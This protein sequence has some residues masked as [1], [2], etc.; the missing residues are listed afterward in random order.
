MFR[1]VIAAMVLATC[2]VAFGGCGAAP[3]N[4]ES[5]TS[6][7]SENGPLAQIGEIYRGHW[8]STKKAPM[9]PKDIAS[10]ADG[11]PDG[12]N[13]V[14]TAAI[15]VIWGVKLDD[16]SIEGNGDSADEVLAYEKATPEAGG[17]Y[18]MKNR[19]IRKMTAAEF[20]AAP[21]GRRR[22]TA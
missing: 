6:A 4:S 21:Q 2:L 19:K 15:V 11:T 17:R 18:L 13:A 9:G 12:V 1:S 7:A 14:K 16:L 10:F 8:L 5:V 22:S 3:P 20:K